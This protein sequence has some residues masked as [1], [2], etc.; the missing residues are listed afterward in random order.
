MGAT[1]DIRLAFRGLRNSPIVSAAAVLSLALGI[2]ANTAIFSVVNALF[3]RALPVVEPHRLVTVSSAFALNHGFKAGAGMNYDMWLRMREHLDA[4]DGGFAWAPGRLDL[5]PGGERHPA[6]ALFTSGKFLTT[7]GVPALI[8]RTFD[9]GDDVRGGG[10]DGLV[11]VISY[12]LWQRR[13]GGAANVIGAALPVEGV[14][15]TIVGVM[16]PD[17]FGVEVGQPFDVI[18]PLAIE[19]AVRG[20]RASIHHPSALMLTVMLRL[21]PGQSVE[22]A[23]AALRTFQSEIVGLKEGQRL[24]EFLTDPYVLVPAAT[25][26]SDRSGLRRQYSRPLMTVL[27][28]VALVLLVACVNVANLFLA[29]ATARRHEMSVRLALGA[30]RWRLGR[31]LLIES[32][33]VA[34]IGA[35]CG[36]LLATWASR[37]VVAGLSTVDTRVSLDLSLDWRVMTVTAGIAVA[38]AILFGM[39]PAIRATRAAPIDA[40]KEQGRVGGTRGDLS[41]GLVVCQVAVSLVLLVSAGLFLSTFRRL[42]ALPLGL[43]PDRVLVVNVDTGRAVIDPSTRVDYFRQLIA[44]VRAVPGVVRAA[45]SMITPFSQ[46]TKSPLFSQPGRAHQH[47]V[48]PGFFDVYGI[49]VRAGRD[50]DERDTA[51][52]PRVVVVSESYARQFLAG[53]DPLAATID[54][55]PCQGPHGRCTVVG[56]VS[57]AVFAPPR[58][59][60]RP[61]RYFPLAQ[62]VGVGPPGRTEIS[63]SVRSATGSPALLARSVTGALTTA[64]RNLTFSYRPLVE[65]LRSALTQERVVAWVSGF[66]GALAL[67]LSALGL[68]GVTAYAVARRRTEIGVR[69][70]LGA[71]SVNVITLLLSRVLAVVL[72]GLAIGVPIALW[73]GKLV[74]SLLYGVEARDTGTIA[75]AAITLGAVA[76]V[77]SLTAASRATRIDPAEVLRQS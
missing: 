43:D 52:S 16:P 26:T 50:F 5:S 46:A 44:T 49:E 63:I 67:L 20:A 23:T 74:G 24:P 38:T 3:L 36:L 40:I 56:V 10:R 41:S 9:D 75:A 73:T 53:L 37:A 57:E 4:F 30:T 13:F 66:F 72:A 65:D 27:A 19:P 58:A 25:G 71:T 48:S 69:V 2:G 55:G 42:A 35:A 64:N 39:G 29:R 18:L 11:A 60:A 15:C 70:A 14:P 17:F 21:K 31:Q 7:L 12:G 6:E 62:S 22:S 76:I 51:N 1:D 59:G 77:A 54:S 32:L 47:V 68:Y 8:G 34:L 28:V 33:V 45:G 61:T